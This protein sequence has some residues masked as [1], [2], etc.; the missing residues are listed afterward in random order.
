MWLKGYQKVTKGNASCFLLYYYSVLLL[1]CR[2]WLNVYRLPFQCLCLS[3]T[4]LALFFSNVQTLQPHCSVNWHTH[5][6]AMY[7]LE[8]MSL[9]SVCV[10]LG[11]TGT[12]KTNV[13]RGAEAEQWVHKHINTTAQHWTDTHSIQ[14]VWLINRR[15]GGWQWGQNRLLHWNVFLDSVTCTLQPPM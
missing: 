1:W 12:L 5:R 11:Q 7:L 13:A 9:L 15:R 2:L 3:P 6:V 14:E 10:F 4:S 8:C